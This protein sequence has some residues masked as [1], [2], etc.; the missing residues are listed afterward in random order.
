MRIADIKENDVVNTLK[1]ISVSVFFQGC[2]HHCK[3]CFNSSTWDFNGV[4]ESDDEDTVKKIIE[5]INKNGVK[6][7]LSLL[8]GEPMWEKNINSTKLIIERVRQI[9]PDIIILIWSGYTIEELKSRNDDIT[10]YILDNINVLIDGRF[11]EDKKD[12]NLKLRG[13]SNQRIIQLK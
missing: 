3:G 2:P 6:R 8:G 4:D 9:Y 10:N 11:E 13:S 1:G 7:N 5:L 12:L